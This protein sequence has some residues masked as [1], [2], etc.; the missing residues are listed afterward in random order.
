VPI[1]FAVQITGVEYFEVPFLLL[2]SCL[3]SGGLSQAAH[4]FPAHFEPVSIMSEAVEYGVSICGI[5]N[6]FMPPRNRKLAG[7]KGG[8]SAISFFKDFQ[9]VMW[10]IAIDWLKSKVVQNQKIDRT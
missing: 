9:E 4:A 10:R 3:V 7:H 8:M 6:L 1:C 5:A 2:A